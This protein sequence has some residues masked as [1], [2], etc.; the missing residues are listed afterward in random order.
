MVGNK[1]ENNMKA[2]IYHPYRCWF[3]YGQIWNIEKEWH[4]VTRAC[5]TEQGAKK[6]LEKWRKSKHPK[7]FE[8]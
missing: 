5:F 3:W 6:E 2:R 7:V 8:I 1:G 4:T